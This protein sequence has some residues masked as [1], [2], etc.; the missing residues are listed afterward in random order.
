MSHRPRAPRPRRRLTAALVALAASV[1]VTGCTLPRKGHLWVDTNGGSCQRSGAAVGY[2]D[3][4]ACGSFQ[5]ALNAAQPGDAVIV[6]CAG[7]ATT[8]SFPAETLSNSKGSAS[9]GIVVVAPAGY[10]VSF[11]PSG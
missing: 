5:R 4:K 7:T 10:R 3:A 6:R 1:A 11:N 2:D 8:C 9:K